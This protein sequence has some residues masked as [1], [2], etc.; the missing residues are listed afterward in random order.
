MMKRKLMAAACAAGLLAVAG[1]MSV[2][3]QS[4]TIFAGGAVS[5][6]AGGPGVEKE[7]QSEL[8]K[9]WGTVLSVNDG[10]I[11]I[12]NQSGNSSAGEVILH[13]SDENTRILDAVNGYPVQLSDVK[14]G[15]VIY[16]YIGPAMTMSLPPQTT[17]EMIICQIPAD[18]K[19]PDYITVKS[20]EKNADGSWTLTSTDETVYQIPADCTIIPYM[21]RQMVY[22]EGVEKGNQLLVW[23]DAENNGQKLVL[24]N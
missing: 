11:S 14:V 24:F 3:A 16:A 8:T 2:M 15:E 17:A 6:E 10:S 23:S 20:M 7:T 4:P 19:A 1:A 12:D 21:T 18:Y 9:I 13:I 5:I 22:L